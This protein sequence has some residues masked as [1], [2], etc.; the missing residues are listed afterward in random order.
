MLQKN[1]GQRSLQGNI[2]AIM[3][4]GQ[5]EFTYNADDLNALMVYLSQ[6]RMAMYMK[7]VIHA[8]DLTDRT[9]KALRRYEYN[10]AVSEALY[11]VIQGFEVASYSGI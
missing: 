10:T 7:A 2:I 8:K 9:R 11:P 3:T 6:E 1:S 4:P 5:I